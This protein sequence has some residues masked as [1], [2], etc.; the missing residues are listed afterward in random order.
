MEYIA[1]S[2]GSDGA[3]EKNGFNMIN[4]LFDEMHY[5]GYIR[6]RGGGMS[7]PLFSRTLTQLL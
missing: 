4:A 3:R 2:F 6:I 1:S 7:N 5:T